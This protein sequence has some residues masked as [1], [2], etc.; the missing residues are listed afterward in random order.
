M[1]R[2]AWARSAQEAADLL[3]EKRLSTLQRSILQQNLDRAKT[4]LDSID[5]D[6]SAPGF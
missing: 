5:K 6:Q 2:P 3:K 4:V 1:H